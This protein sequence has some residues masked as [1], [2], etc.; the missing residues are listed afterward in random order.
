MNYLK[1]KFYMIV[2]IFAS[3]FVLFLQEGKSADKLPT[4]EDLT[5]GKVKIGD[6]IDKNNVDLV[7][8]YLGVSV[9]ELVK[10]GMV[11]RMANQLSPRQFYPKQF[12]D[13]TERNK[14]KAVIDENGTVYLKDGSIWPG[15]FPF[16][17]STTG[18]EIMANVK[19]GCFWD[20]TYAPRTVKF[21][22]KNGEVYDTNKAVSR[23]LAMTGRL[24]NPPIGVSP[25]CEQ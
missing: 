3:F 22:N 24:T 6:L 5:E 18:L 23:H 4:I 2:M 17:E 12:Y 20:D 8:E 11:L 1:S 10:N 14:G 7:K 21:V 9:Y 13:A 16:P 15:G 25:G 19:F